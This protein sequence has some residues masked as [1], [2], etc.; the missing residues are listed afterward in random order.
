MRDV[1]F[2]L[3]CGLAGWG[4]LAATAHAGDVTA[5]NLVISQAWSRATPSGAQVAGGYLTIDNKGSLPDR[6][7]SA[8]T[9]AARKVEM[10][11]M[12]LD[13]GIMTMR[14]VDGGLFIEA[15]KAVKFEPGGRHLMLIGLAAPLTEGSQV[16]V[17]LAFEQAGQVTVP[18]AVQGIGGRAPAPLTRVE[19]ARIYSGRR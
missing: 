8:S 12:A 16:S 5:G 9:G 7:L 18:F 19:A 3:V 6:L 10:H 15:G 14:P 1:A 4:L 11:E 2:G 13:K 17:S